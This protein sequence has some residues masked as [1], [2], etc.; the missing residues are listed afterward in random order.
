MRVL[1]KSPAFTAISVLT[2]AL[3]IG[4]NTAVFSLINA[5]IFKML[6]VKDPGQ[7]VVVGDPTKVH[8]R[9][10]GTPQVDLFSYPLY[11]ELRN[12]TSVF[13]GLLASGEVHRT[14]VTDA[15][16]RD[17]PGD[18]LAVLVSGNYFS[19][20]GVNTIIGRPLTAE[21]D[22]APGAHPVVVVSYSFWENKL[23]RNPAIVGQPLRLNNYPFTVIGVAPPGF[24]GDTVGDSQDI[25]APVTMQEQIIAGRHW[26]ED[27]QT[28]WLHL[29]GRL[30]PGVSVAQAAANVDVAFRQFVKGP[31]MAKVQR[32]DR[33]ELKKSRIE[34]APGGNGF[35]RV[36]GEAS[37][38]LLI[39]MSFVALVL[40][41]ACVNVANLLLARASARQREMAVRMAIGAAP[42]R[43]I[44]QLLTESVL[45]A[46]SGGLAGLLAAQ[47][48]TKA[49]L[50]VSRQIDL[51][52][53]PDLRVLLFTAG[54]CVVTGILFGLIPA[55][56][57]R[58]LA[59]TTALKSGAQGSGGP[60]AST[61]NWGKLLVIGQV[62]LSLLT[63]FGAG[64][65]VRSLENLK[66][67][68]LGY[69]REHILTVS[70]DPVA[71]GYKTPEIVNF[72]NELTTRLSNVPGVR[73]ATFSMNGLFSGSESNGT[74]EIE[75]ITPKDN[76]EPLSA[77]DWVGPNYFATV[78][79]P[80]LVG[81]DIG[82]QDTAASSKVVVINESFAKL[83]LGSAN[84]IGRKLIVDDDRGKKE[85]FEIV[86]VV[87][88]SRI[89]ELR[90]KIQPRFYI[91]MAQM[92]L[93]PFVNFEIKTAGNPVPVAD[94]A[95]KLIKEYN[96]AIPIDST[97]T[98]D[99]LVIRLITNDILMA[100]LSS[101][102]A[103][104]ALLL[105]CVGLYGI[106]SYS[107]TGR[108]REL[109]VR[110]A[111]G[112]QRVDVLW[113]VLR[114]GLKLVIIGVAVGI[115]VALLSTRVLTS[116]LFGLSSFD[117]VS[118]TTVILLLAIVALFASYIP[119]RRA[120][121]VDPMVALRYE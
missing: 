53:S 121:K 56:R 77:I 27:I 72:A 117:P 15:N 44:R 95:R 28:S 18:A 85:P 34:V 119:A 29:I 94:A 71:A 108:T 97:R 64:L 8:S 38:P 55:L 96:A 35:S 114:E 46:F 50:R 16:G 14:R 103:G 21:D 54:V 20:L 33:E 57:A 80:M 107:V 73:A 88:D 115:P 26:L 104:L 92:Q 39:L 111:L 79:V 68:D 112:A 82:P 69:S 75:G 6:P 58:Y 84:P 23:G 74:F 5:L 90:E 91:P 93:V 9:S 120:T 78:G 19:V 37:G 105:A 17:I 49:L 42:G 67:I 25:W 51:Q 47:W 3:G 1:R 83:Y 98:V 62:V 31:L 86:G 60:S 101:V 102:F 2:L 10:S 36:R 116:V 70:T 7:L 45:L 76:K 12:D 106:M 4:A 48:G 32:N 61:W 59:V 41:I 81:R 109:G 89:S 24:Y 113:L 100:E 63:L 40:L 110:I 118:M 43:I 66:S 11:R 87:R 52:A 30:N 13:S 99:E 22:S 65:L